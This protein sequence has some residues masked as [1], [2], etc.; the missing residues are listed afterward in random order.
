MET[1]AYCMVNEVTNVV[2]N[3]VSWNGSD[4]WIP[5]EGYLMIIQS[6]TPAKIWNVDVYTNMVTL[7]I[8]IGAGSI[9]FTWDGTYLNT[10]IIEPIL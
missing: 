3:I 8:E 5:P 2:D 6:I 7:V 9:G 10:N 1:Q 4:E